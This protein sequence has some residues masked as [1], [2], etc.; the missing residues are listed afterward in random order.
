MSSMVN[1]DKV[2][3]RI[4][5]PERQ[6]LSEPVDEVVLPGEDGYLGVRPGHAPL[7]ARLQIGEVSYW[8]GGEQRFIAISGGYAEILRERVSVLAETAEP[9]DQIDVERAKRAQQAAQGRLDGKDPQTDF[10]R[11]EVKLKRALNRIS[12]A[13]RVRV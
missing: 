1:T 8:V 11:A 12:T 6:V 9:A 4:V 2:E 3:L 5:T 10:R 13:A 7:L